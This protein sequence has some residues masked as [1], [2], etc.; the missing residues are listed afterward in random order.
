MRQNTLIENKMQKGKKRGLRR[1][2]IEPGSTAW[3]AAMLTTIPPTPLRG[4]R[5]QIK[6]HSHNLFKYSRIFLAFS[7]REL[8]ASAKRYPQAP[9]V[10]FFLRSL[11]VS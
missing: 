6:S 3:K 11:F 5:G 4:T 8:D 2:G 9:L 10:G 1:P 7:A